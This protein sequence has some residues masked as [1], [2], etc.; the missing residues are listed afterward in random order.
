[1]GLEELEENAAGRYT[2]QAHDALIRKDAIRCCA[3]GCHRW[4]AKRSRGLKD[5]NAFCPDHGVSVSA[6]PTY[7]F[8]DYRHNFIIDVPILERVKLLKVESWRLGNERSEDALSWNVFVGLAGLGGLASTFHSLTGIKVDVEPELYLW[9]VRIPDE[10]PCLWSR[11]REVRLVL[12]EG[13]G[14]PTEPDVILRVPGRAIVLIEAKFGSPN[15]SMLGNEERFGVPSEFLDRYPCVA[16]KVDPLNRAWIEGQPP[17]QI[18]QQLLRN[19]IFAQW[20]AEENEVPFVVNLVRAADE[21]DIEE[22]LTA[23]L[24][25]NGSVCFRRCTWERLFQ[26]PLL[27]SEN[28]RPLRRYFENKTNRLNRAFNTNGGSS[29]F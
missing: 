26:L 27:S 17:G 4:L 23:H 16:G 6:S 1:M 5:P 22:R 29:R 18:L 8:N 9:G 10:Q 19:V 11:L 3:H 21:A 13:A 20:L 2:L 28:A 25:A 14:W 15:G 7:V 24:A 12:Q